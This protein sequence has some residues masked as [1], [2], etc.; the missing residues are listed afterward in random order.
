MKYILALIGITLL[1][2]AWVKFQLWLKHI[3]PDRGDFHPGCGAC[4]GGSCGNAPQKSP[5]TASESRVPLPHP[6]SSE[7]HSGEK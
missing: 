5:C 4:Q 6:L 1:C 2:A 3:D 7:Q